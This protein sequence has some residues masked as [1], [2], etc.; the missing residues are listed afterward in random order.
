MTP[1]WLPLIH[2][3]ERFRDVYT[4]ARVL[5]T[6]GAGFV[7]S[8]LCNVLGWLGA[9]VTAL[10]DL[11]TGDRANL[12]APNI[13]FAQGSV[14]DFPFVEQHV[15]GKD[16][17]FHLAVRNIML[18]ATEVQADCAV[19]IGGTVNALLAAKNQP[20]RPMF[21]YA[22]SVSIYGNA[23]IQ[24][25]ADETPFD[26]LTPYAASKLAGENY[27][28]AFHAMHGMR[29]ASVRYSN[30]Y[31]VNQNVSNPYCG[32]IAKF[33]DACARGEACTVFGEGTQTRDYV[34]IG[35]AIEG[36]LLGGTAAAAL[37][38]ACNLGTGVETSVVDL[39]G[40]IA[41]VVGTQAKLEFKPKRSID[42]VNRRSASPAGAARVLGW[43][44][45]V[46]LA[47][48]LMLT[49]RWLSDSKAR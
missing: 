23:K 42:S 19:N 40:A 48:G 2:Q 15:A 36:T 7:G 35:D 26:T 9:E 41:K 32:V 24:P 3:V 8:N 16:Y 44:P 22:S 4:G 10:D 46:A 37:G 11:S 20:V 47:D 1:H 30:V 18:S 17:V 12:C 39:A 33:F 5:V 21:V 38:T 14:T 25:I 45:T 43:K 31:G 49:H 27:A 34:W 29:V 6:G 13:T 28:R